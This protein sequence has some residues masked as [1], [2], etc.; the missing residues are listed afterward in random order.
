MGSVV[1]AATHADNGTRWLDLVATRANWPSRAP[2]ERLPDLDTLSS[3]LE[4]H[5]LAPEAQPTAADFIVV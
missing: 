5:A 2:V 4:L 1:L 3:W